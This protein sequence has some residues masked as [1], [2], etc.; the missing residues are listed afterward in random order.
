VEKLLNF[1][2]EYEMTCAAQN[3]DSRAWMALFNHYEDL[4][5][6]QL[7]NVKGLTR[8]ELKSEAV[9]V[10]AQEIIKFDKAKVKS[11]NS[12]SLFSWLWC[13]VLNRTNK[14]IRKRKKDVHL[15]FEDV[16][17]AKD[18]FIYP[19]KTTKYLNTNSDDDLSPLESQMVGVNEEVY[20]TYNPEKLTVTKLQAS[21]TER[22]KAFYAKLSQFE[23]D[24]LIARRNGLTLAQ[25]ATKF[26]C[27]VT[28]I[29]NHI[30]RVKKHASDVFQICY[31]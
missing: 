27:S 24:I 8:Q 29:K 11:E 21:D 16:N 1:K 13:R 2:N 31:A 4:L 18:G 28:T 15:Y 26:C 10:F 12:Y 5:M 17:A 25:V 6:S 20:T 30:V 7:Y 14:L 22:V 9:D 3:G 23:K 19:E